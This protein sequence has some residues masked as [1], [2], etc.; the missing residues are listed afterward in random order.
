MPATL[1][2]LHMHVQHL[3]DSSSVSR[4][5]D[6]SFH[7][8]MDDGLG[9]LV[10]KDDPL[11]NP[12]FNAFSFGQQM[13]QSTTNFDTGQGTGAVFRR[14]RVFQDDSSGDEDHQI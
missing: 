6:D 8:D 12:D 7:I 14:A 9:P 13:Q 10:R 2:G 5:K 3:Q 4:D 11:Q 1:D